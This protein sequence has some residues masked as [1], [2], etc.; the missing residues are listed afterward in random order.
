[1]R[2]SDDAPARPVLGIAALAALL[3]VAVLA[4][5]AVAPARPRGADAP[6]GVFSATRAVDQLERIADVPRPVG[7]PGH[8]LAREHL[9]ATLEAWGWRTEVHEAVGATDFGQAGTQPVAL[10]RNVVATWPGTDPTGTV[11]L[12]AHYDTVAGSPGAAD[13]GVTVHV[14]VTALGRVRGDDFEWLVPGL[15]SELVTT[16]IRS[17]PKDLRRSLLPVPDVAVQVLSR[18]M[19]R[20]ARRQA[21]HRCYR[22]PHRAAT[23]R[24]RRI[25]A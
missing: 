3:L 22:A 18:F 19:S 5:F 15:R 7:S 4:V 10:A 12:A 9:L 6:A 11:V 1:M 13:D 23:P 21:A 2:T 24:G 14:P 17:L 16:L 25:R 20:R 8:A